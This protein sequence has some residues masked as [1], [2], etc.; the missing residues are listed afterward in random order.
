[1]MGALT[2]AHSRG[3]A[4]PKVASIFTSSS[5][6][7]LLWRLLPYRPPTLNRR[8]FSTS[9][10]V[11]TRKEANRTALKSPSEPP[12]YCGKTKLRLAFVFRAA[13]RSDIDATDAVS[14]ATPSPTAF[15]PAFWVRLRKASLSASGGLDMG[16][17]AG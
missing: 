15:C 11:S 17:S 12:A 4:E 13:A 3:E 16:A 14:Q 7:A 10:P 2:Q 5:I 1:M 9:H 8:S 6:S